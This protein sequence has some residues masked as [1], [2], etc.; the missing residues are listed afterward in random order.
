MPERELSGKGRAVHV[1]DDAFRVRE[2]ARRRQ[3]RQV[4]REPRAR[5]G[6]HKV[7]Y[8]FGRVFAGLRR[9]RRCHAAI[10][11]REYFTRVRIVAAPLKRAV[12]GH[13]RIR[14]IKHGKGL[15]AGSAVCRSLVRLPDVVPG[16]VD[17]PLLGLLKILL[18][19][20]HTAA[21]GPKL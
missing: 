18:S 4:E 12:G 2:A 17:V 5:R 20:K 6:D 11:A 8:A 13:E 21:D 16:Q 14:I 9:D 7:V 19:V 3:V 10:V 15:T 1:Q